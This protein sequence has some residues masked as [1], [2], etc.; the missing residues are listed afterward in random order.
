MKTLK[1]LLA[2]ILTA[3]GVALTY[4]Y[5]EAIVHH[6][7][8]GVWN[9]WLDTGDH[10]WLIVPAC[11]L[12]GLL[13]FG[14]QHRLDPKSEQHES[15]GLGDMPAPTIKNFG[16]VLFIGSLSLLAGASL[17][18]EAILVPACTIL[19]SYIGVKSFDK[20][21]RTVKL[22]GMVSLIALLA[23]F[24]HSFLA[25]MLG[26]LLVGKQAKLKP[27]VPL[28]V[29]AAIASGVTVWVLGILSS[30]SFVALPAT[31]WK[32]NIR[33]LLAIIILVGTGYMT[34]Y[35]IGGFHQL[36]EAVHR[37]IRREDWWQRA[38]VAAAGLSV[39]YLLGGTL[40]EFTGNDSV[41]PML[42]RAASLGVIGLLWILLVKILAISWSKAMAIAA[43]WSS[44]RSSWPASWWRSPTPTSTILI[45]STA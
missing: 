24:F 16:K 34:T 30:P 35:A 2:T 40:V 31:T 27:S 15:H 28:I 25:G 38:L 39:L 10:R 13:Y 45:S 19:G 12:L 36:A 8:D 26:L 32:F 11:L 4:Y 1:V 6:S 43:A 22:L 3:I 5:F 17:G 44:Q 33:S 14:L 23:A 42:H 21:K 20:D 18:P 9:S 37:R 7:I 29:L 41:V